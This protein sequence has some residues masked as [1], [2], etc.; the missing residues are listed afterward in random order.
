MKNEIMICFNPV[1]AEKR[2]SFV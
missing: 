1:V 2:V